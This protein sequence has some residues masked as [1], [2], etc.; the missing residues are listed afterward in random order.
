MTERRWIS[1]PAEAHA[2]MVK[3]NETIDRIVARLRVDAMVG[4]TP[5]PTFVCVCRG[6]GVMGRTVGRFDVG[7]EKRHVW[8]LATED[9]PVFV[10]CPKCNPV[11]AEDT[12]KR[13]TGTYS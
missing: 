2:A 9:D 3:K 13:R 1:S 6:T 10:R 4:G 7:N 12:K 5:E 8:V 11:Q